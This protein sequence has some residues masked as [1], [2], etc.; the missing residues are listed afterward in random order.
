M[1][2]KLFAISLLFL[3][4]AALAQSPAQS[5]FT[6]LKAL[7]G[8]WEGKTLQGAPVN[9]DYKLTASG[10]A[11]MSTIHEHGD[12]ISMFHLDGPDK[13]LLT[14]YCSMGN[15]PRMVATTS[16][17]GKSVTFRFLDVTNL[18]APDAGHMDSLV[19]AMVDANHHT[20]EWNFKDHNKMVKEVFDLRRV[21]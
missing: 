21:N 6:Q 13:L 14:H 9:V 11:L 12:M 2:M 4:T 19:I 8:T 7:A 3:S 15:Q 5:E 10:S 1:T 17:D 16:A 20:E 18:S